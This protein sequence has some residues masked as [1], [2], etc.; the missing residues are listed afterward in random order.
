MK[1]LLL[2]SC[3]LLFCKHTECVRQIL[4]GIIECVVDRLVFFIDRVRFRIG[5]VSSAGADITHQRG[6]IFEALIPHAE[7]CH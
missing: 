1:Q 4:S 3:V 5:R 2:L 7:R 6:I